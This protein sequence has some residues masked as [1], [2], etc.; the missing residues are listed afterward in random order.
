VAGGQLQ[1]GQMGATPNVVMNRRQKSI[2]KLILI[3]L[4][5]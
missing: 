4:L 3:L 1:C 5:M 2:T